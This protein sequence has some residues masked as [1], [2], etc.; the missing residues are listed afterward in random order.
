[1]KILHLLM[2]LFSYAF[3]LLPS[4]FLA[5]MGVVAYASNQ[6]TWRLESYPD[7]G[8]KDVSNLFLAI[9]L[10]GLLAVALAFFNKFRYLL[11]LVALAFLVGFVYTFFWQ[12]YRF[13]GS[14]EFQ[15]ALALGAGFFGNFLCSLMEFR[16]PQQR[17]LF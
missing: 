16:R 6:H 4:A 15:W 8:G 13:S 9:G 3:T 12:N 2:R 7:L 1:M 14:E 5:G 11:P 17:F 10:T